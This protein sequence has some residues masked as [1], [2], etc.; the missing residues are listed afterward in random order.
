MW[1]IDHFEV[2]DSWGQSCFFC[3]VVAAAQ[4]V[5]DPFSFIPHTQPHIICH[6]WSCLFVAFVHLHWYTTFGSTFVSGRRTRPNKI[7]R[8][9]IRI[10]MW[11]YLALFVCQS[12]CTQILIFKRSSIGT[13]W[14]SNYKIYAID[15]SELRFCVMTTSKQQLIALNL[16]FCAHM[17]NYILMLKIVGR[18]SHVTPI[19]SILSC[20]RIIV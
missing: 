19:P 5:M 14:S 2:L 11:A 10:T 1:D 16:I 13:S 9:R 6:L 3:Q 4:S 18:I 8:N 7:Y 15:F 20:M 12:V 17:I